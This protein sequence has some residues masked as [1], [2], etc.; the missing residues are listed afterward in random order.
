MNRVIAPKRLAFGIIAAT[1]ALSG[2]P[3]SAASAKPG[4][5]A[6]AVVDVTKVTGGLALILGPAD[7]PLAAE[8]ARDGKFLVLALASDEKPLDAAR[9]LLHARGLYG[10]ASVQVLAGCDH[11]IAGDCAEVHDNIPE[12]SG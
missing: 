2:L 10:Q 8:L 6:A 5:R 4:D 9:R 1:L 12:Y 3:A 11:L 7:G